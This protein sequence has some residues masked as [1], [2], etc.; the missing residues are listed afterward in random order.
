M[1]DTPDLVASDAQTEFYERNDLFIYIDGA[2]AFG[3]RSGQ[4][5][6]WGNLCSCMGT[7]IRP[8]LGYRAYFRPRI[9]APTEVTEQATEST[10]M[11]EWAV[12]STE[13]FRECKAYDL[14]V[15]PPNR[16]NLKDLHHPKP[17]ELIYT[18]ITLRDSEPQNPQRPQRARKAPR[19][20]W[21]VY[22]RCCI[23]GTTSTSIRNDQPIDVIIHHIFP[24]VHW[25]LWLQANYGAQCPDHGPTGHELDSDYIGYHHMC[26]LNNMIPLRRD[27]HILFD[28][29]EVGIDVHNN[30]RVISFSEGRA[31]L[32]VYHLNLDGIEVQ[33][34]P[35]KV[36]LEDHLTQGV[37]RHC[38]PPGSLR[39]DT[40]D[41]DVNDA[42][43]PGQTAG[44]EQT[45][46]QTDAS[47]ELSLLELED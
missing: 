33:H 38:L 7:V 24:R 8:L 36:L 2:L 32:T 10:E 23:T 5:V 12:E 43:Q 45:Q 34:R 17:M 27:L 14:L 40:E 31:D 42:V 4:N 25:D 18:K 22:R 19:R 30:Y 46:E 44:S 9:S 39:T 26:C 11:I 28:L 47:H 16:D 3:F 20:C 21:E 37:L 41:D 13:P 6:N 29:Y 1:H 15:S 35:L